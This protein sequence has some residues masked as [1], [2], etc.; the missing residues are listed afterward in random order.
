MNKGMKQEISGSVLE[1]TSTPVCRNTEASGRER[2]EKS[3]GG[4]NRDCFNLK[5]LIPD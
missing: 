5:V 2:L 4:M 1:I 3:T